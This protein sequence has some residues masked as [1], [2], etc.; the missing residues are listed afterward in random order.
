MD[1]NTTGQLTA[2]LRPWVKDA[3]GYIKQ[4]PDLVAEMAKCLNQDGDVRIVFHIRANAITVEAADYN[5]G[6][7][8]ELFR[9]HLLGDD[10]FGHD[11]Q[12]R[13]ALQ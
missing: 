2:A 12:L 1:P 7:M 8:A 3:L 4:R 11:F 5:E 9:Q 6:T 13:G 10:G